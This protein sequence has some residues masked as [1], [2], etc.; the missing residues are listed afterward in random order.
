MKT[1]TQAEILDMPKLYRAAFINSIAGFKPA[2]LVGT[3]DKAGN[4]NL[5]IF[6]SIVHIGAHPPLIGFIHRPV[7]VE[8]HTYENIHE[9]GEY[10]LNAVHTEMYEQ[11]HHTSARY[12]REVSEF[13]QSDLTAQY[14]DGI[15]VPFVGESRIQLHVKF[16]EEYP[17]TINNTI[18]IVGSIEQ[19]FLSEDLVLEDGYISHQKA[20]SVAIGGLD[21]YYKTE[22]IATLPYAK[23]KANEV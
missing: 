6:N 19:V 16:Q 7:S 22:E 1:I 4:E 10:T 17:I 5:A 23:P 11:A 14:R 9:L 12:N 20:G 2:M 21:R 8:R 3:T 18:L 13:E 15:S